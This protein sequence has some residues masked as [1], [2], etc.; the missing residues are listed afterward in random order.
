MKKIMNKVMLTCKKATYY[1]SVKNYTNLSAPQQMQLKFHLMM[2]PHCRRFDAQ[3]SQ[4]D[5]SI[6]NFAK[7][8][9]KAEMHLTD[10]KKSEIKDTLNQHL[11]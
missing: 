2:C 5:E 10:L 4:I 11:N 8:G 9:H 3:S 1:S 6:S 7:N